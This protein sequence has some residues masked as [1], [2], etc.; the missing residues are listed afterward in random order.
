MQVLLPCEFAV[1]ANDLVSRAQA[2][3]RIR[4]RKLLLPAVRGFNFLAH[5]GSQVD[6]LFLWRL[7]P[8]V[9][10]QQLDR[11]IDEYVLSR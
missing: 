2:D 8:Q 1:F 6:G 5:P 7:T 4:E 3:A 11:R 10:W 9:M